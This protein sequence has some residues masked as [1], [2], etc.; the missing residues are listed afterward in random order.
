[1]AK[2][3]QRHNISIVSG[4]IVAC[5][6]AWRR[7]RPGP[8]PGGFVDLL[9][10]AYPGRARFFQSRS[11]RVPHRWG[12]LRRF[13]ASST[14]TSGKRSRLQTWPCKR[15]RPPRPA[16]IVTHRGPGSPPPATRPKDTPP[17]LTKQR[18]LNCIPKFRGLL[19]LLAADLPLSFCGS[20]AAQTKSCSSARL[21]SIFCTML[22]SKPRRNASLFGITWTPG[23]SSFHREP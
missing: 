21:R 5:S 2:S 13:S 11:P 7:P 3:D 4:A 18:C 1:V 6:L 12:G 8:G 9:C 23:S 10:V 20:Q 17:T 19:A 14:R 15:G 16:P 22:P